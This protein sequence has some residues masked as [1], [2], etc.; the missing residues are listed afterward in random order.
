MWGGCPAVGCSGTFFEIFG[1][2]WLFWKNILREIILFDQK[3]LRFST[4]NL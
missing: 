2:F 3:I 4:N 1:Y